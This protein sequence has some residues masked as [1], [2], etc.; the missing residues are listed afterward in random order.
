VQLSEH[1]A[2]QAMI[3]FLR[4]YARQVSDPDPLVLLIHDLQH[5]KDSVP[6]DP[7]SWTDWLA[8]IEAVKRDG[9]QYDPQAL[10]DWMRREAAAR[11]QRQSLE[12]AHAADKPPAEVD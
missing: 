7:A 10:E 4:E 2:Y 5:L 8:A 1:E 11:E 12:Q 6:S 9:L 3:L